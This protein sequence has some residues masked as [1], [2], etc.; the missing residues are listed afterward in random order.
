MTYI[1]QALR[2]TCNITFKK[3]CDLCL[4]GNTIFISGASRNARIITRQE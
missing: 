3:K 4:E 1:Q 2:Y